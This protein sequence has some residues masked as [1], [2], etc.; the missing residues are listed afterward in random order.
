MLFSTAT[1]PDLCNELIGDDSSAIING[2]RERY[3]VC[4]EENRKAHNIDGH[5][6]LHS[7]FYFCNAS[8]FRLNG[9]IWLNNVHQTVR[10]DKVVSI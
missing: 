7:K 3:E 9:V 5:K 2:L 1:R 8:Y 4:E 6:A 10:W